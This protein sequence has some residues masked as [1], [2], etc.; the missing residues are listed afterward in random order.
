MSIFYSMWKK[1]KSIQ[2]LAL[3]H[4][5]VAQIGPKASFC[6]GKS[7]SPHNFYTAGEPRPPVT[8]LTCAG[9]SP[10]EA[11]VLIWTQKDLIKPFSSTTAKHNV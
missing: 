11:L 10:H 7:R 2:I 6:W 3:I 9:L 4:K 8:T 5:V 1:K